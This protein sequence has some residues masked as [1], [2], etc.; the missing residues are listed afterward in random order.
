MSDQL[1]TVYSSALD[2]MRRPGPKL[3]YPLV[4]VIGGDA[5]L[6]TGGALR[7]YLDAAGPDDA[8]RQTFAHVLAG[9]DHASVGDAW[10]AGTE[11]NTSER[12]QTI[13]AALGLDE[14]TRTL[15]NSLFPL[16]RNE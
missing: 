3:L 6:A 13:L 12:R 5:A 16:L 7:T 15:F 9:W 10:T 11:P 2:A 8:L 4:A 14:S 1:A